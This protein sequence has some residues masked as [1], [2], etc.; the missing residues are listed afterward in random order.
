M[1]EEA[2]MAKP[3]R[4]RLRLHRWQFL[5][6]ADGQRYRECR[7]C[8][9]QRIDVDKQGPG[10]MIGDRPPQIAATPDG[11]CY[12]WPWLR[13]ALVVVAVAHRRLGPSSSA[14]TS[15]TDRTLPSS[16]VPLRCWSRPTTMPRP[17][18]LTTNPAS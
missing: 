12:Y 9:K 1:P 10:P 2:A 3:W 18:L 11:S 5:R 6:G 13:A 8:G 16:A 4:C 15:T 14:T 17:L 7:A